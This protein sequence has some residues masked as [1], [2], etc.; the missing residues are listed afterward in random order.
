MPAVVQNMLLVG[1]EHGCK[2][3]L[4]DMSCRIDLQE[5]IAWDG[6]SYTY[7]EFLAW[8]GKDADSM[9]KRAAVIVHDYTSQRWC[10]DAYIYAG[11]I[12]QLY[13]QTRAELA[14]QTAAAE[15]A[16][17]IAQRAQDFAAEMSRVMAGHILTI[18][19]LQAEAL[20]HEKALEASRAAE[21][22][23]ETSRDEAKRLL[24]ELCHLETETWCSVCGNKWR[25]TEAERERELS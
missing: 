8:Y 20:E 25:E 2:T 21:L 14:S 6:L 7:E 19:R 22:E 24:I 5:R 18:E 3:W 17:S 23:A 4:Q 12:E 15:A 16:N 9:W 1:Q 13:A 11:Q 10:K